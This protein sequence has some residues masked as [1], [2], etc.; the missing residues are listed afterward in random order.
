MKTWQASVEQRLS[1]RDA[2]AVLTRDLIARFSRSA[3]RQRGTEGI[4]ASSLSHWIKRMTERGKLQL[5]QR[6]IYLNRMRSKPGTLADAIPLLQ[7]DAVVSLNTVLGEAGV[8]NNPSRVITA[9]VPIDLAAPPPSRLGRRQTQAG[10]VHFYG[11]PRSILEA[12][13]AEDRLESMDAFDHP[14][15]TPEKALIDW[16]YLGASPRSRRTPPP[17]S[18][19]DLDMLNGKRLRRLAKAVGL[20]QQLDSFSG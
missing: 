16:L 11:I 10:I 17:R 14:R 8:L 20:E 6:G 4:P 5:V 12:G 15:A 1:E 2:P 7:R 19:I 13:S 18:D 9:V 3:N